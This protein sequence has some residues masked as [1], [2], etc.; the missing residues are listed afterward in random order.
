M[1]KAL[2]VL[3]FHNFNDEEF[4]NLKNFLEK[5]GIET[6]T[7]SFK[8][9]WAM[10][11]SGNEVK[12]DFSISEVNENH[13]DLLI[14]CSPSSLKSFDN[15]N[16]YSLIKKFFQKKKLIIGLSLAPVIFAKAGILKG[17]KATVWS[18]SFDKKGIEVLKEKGAIISKEKIVCDGNVITLQD[19][20]FLS[21][22]DFFWKDML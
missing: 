6:K 19:S 21:D 15:E 8:K 17:K 11:A 2:I 10:G 1:K 9:G 22:L 16:L 5:R 14:V 18:S 20:S 13:F 7:A 4:F 3:D 12:I